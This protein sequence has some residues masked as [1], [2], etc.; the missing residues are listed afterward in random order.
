[1]RL[2]AF[3]NFV[4]FP[5]NAICT[6]STL[7][8]AFWSTDRPLKKAMTQCKVNSDTTEMEKNGSSCTCKSILNRVFSKGLVGGPWEGL[9]EVKVRH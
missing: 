6:T 1:M 7:L 3:N 8:A 4:K 2:T 5:S 9:M